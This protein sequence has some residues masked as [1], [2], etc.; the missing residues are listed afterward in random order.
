MK[1]SVR[2]TLNVIRILVPSAILALATTIHAQQPPPFHLEEATITDI[3]N[4]IKS[5]QTTCQA[6]V[7]AYFNRAKAYNGTCTALVTKDGT[8]IPAAPGIVRAGAP[9]KF[10]TASRSGFQRASRFRQIQRPANG[11]RPNGADDFRSQRST[12][13]WYARRDSERR[14]VECA[15]DAQYSRRTFRHLQR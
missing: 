5:G 8:P 15:R 11:T 4:A 12:A 1:K 2:T 10:P 9:L 7:Q 6:V 13:V 3:Q 14:T